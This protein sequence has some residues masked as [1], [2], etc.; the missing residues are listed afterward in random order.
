MA[1][2]KEK[3]FLPSLIANNILTNQHQETFGTLGNKQEKKSS[4]SQLNN[5]IVGKLLF[6]KFKS[7][8]EKQAVKA[9]DVEPATAADVQ[10]V[11][12]MLD[13]EIKVSKINELDVIGK[14]L[15][16]IANV[17]QE[18]KDGIKRE[19]YTNSQVQNQTLVQSENVFK[20]DSAALADNLDVPVASGSRYSNRTTPNTEVPVFTNTKNFDRLDSQSLFDDFDIPNSD[21]EADSSMGSI[22]QPRQENYV[23]DK[24]TTRYVNSRLA[25]QEN[26]PVFRS[27]LFEDDFGGEY[28]SVYESRSARY[29]NVNM[30]Q[31]E[32]SREKRTHRAQH[33]SRAKPVYYE[34]PYPMY[35]DNSGYNSRANYFDPGLISNLQMKYIQKEHIQQQ[36]SKLKDSTTIELELK[37]KKIYEKGS[38]E[39]VNRSVKNNNRGLYASVVPKQM[40]E[41]KELAGSFYISGK[42]QDSNGVG[43][44]RDRMY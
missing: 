35:Y 37:S 27:S 36:R 29:S 4:L 30:I 14:L 34:N 15:A 33:V 7:P 19:R 8:D 20:G 31:K 44:W 6:R 12:K 18:E 41:E 40:S 16:D 23:N 42:D 1:N 32:L 43:Y 25:K 5:T 10:L 11:E 3:D 22:M 17:K 38:N 13:E 9:D 21:Y 28:D 24:V 39:K 2:M 26:I